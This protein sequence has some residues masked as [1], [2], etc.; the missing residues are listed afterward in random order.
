MI[1]KRV[2]ESDFR[3]EEVF[4]PGSWISAHPQRLINFI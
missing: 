1:F 3:E 4:I 2:K